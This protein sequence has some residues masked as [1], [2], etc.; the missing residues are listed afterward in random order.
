MKA[1][2]SPGDEYL[3]AIKKGFYEHTIPELSQKDIAGID[4]AAIRE[5][6]RA[7]ESSKAEIKIS[8]PIIAYARV[9]DL[10]ISM[11]ATIS[12]VG[13]F[14]DENE[15]CYFIFYGTDGEPLSRFSYGFSV[16]KSNGKVSR[17]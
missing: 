16:N 11:V 14:T 5:R 8:D 17:Y 3:L 9:L 15:D 4:I 6:A 12:C 13:T 2:I 10:G 7:L 1:L